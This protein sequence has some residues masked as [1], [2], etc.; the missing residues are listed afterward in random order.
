M[1]R[2]QQ[3]PE[4]GTF[5][6]LVSLHR[7]PQYSPHR[8]PMPMPPRD[9]I[10]SPAYSRVVPFGKPLITAGRAGSRELMRKQKA[11]APGGPSVGLCGEEKRINLLVEAFTHRNMPRASLEVLHN[12]ADVLVAHQPAQNGR[13]LAIF[14]NML[15]VRFEVL[16]LVV[17]RLPRLEL[18]PRLGHASF[19]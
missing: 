17:L 4:Y 6:V 16:L 14:E 2:F 7:Q 13:G 8:R 9:F 18:F 12:V 10:T 15:F 19:T 3:I 11:L 5:A 1:N